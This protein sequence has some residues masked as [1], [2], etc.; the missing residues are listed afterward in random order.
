M[1]LFVTRRRALQTT[2]AALA[3]LLVAF[4]IYS[5][6]QAGK[7]NALQ[8]SISASYERAFY[9]TASLLNNI[10]V[11]LE[12]AQVTG[13]GA[14]RVSLLG[15]IGRDAASAQSNL[16]ALP[17]SMAAISESLKFV[18][19]VGDIAATLSER[20]NGDLSEE[21]IELLARLHGSCVNLNNLI[22]GIV[23]DIEGGLNPLA[24]AAA[25]APVMA[26]ENVELRETEIDYPILLYDGPFSDG[27]GDAVFRALSGDDISAD[28]ALRIARRFIGED[29]ISGAW[30]AGES[31]IPMPCYEISAYTGDGLLSLAVSK[32]G[33]HAVYMMVDG[34]A[35]ERLHSQASLIDMAASF[36]KS[37]GYPP[38]EVSY[39]MTFDGYLTVNFAAVQDG[40]LLYPDLIKVQMSMESGLPVGLEAVNFLANHA[41]RR[42]PEPKLD[43]NEARERLNSAL[44]AER[45][46][47]CVI[48]LNNG[49]A[50][51]WEFSASADGARYLVYIDAMTGEER[52]IYRVVEDENGQLVI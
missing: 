42:L 22:D 29:R 23:S 17:A 5:R 24:K 26:A 20:P 49:E 39:W 47:L 25:G 37:R 11:N 50:F 28:E 52:N 9:E 40:V 8:T 44:T 27:R 6:A 51:C 48:P 31:E 43:E 38:V 35:R 46:R 3:A 10:E 18:N 41:E 15:Q 36:L 7:I 33:G 16:T 13:S 32:Q 21:E 30:I 1:K 14:R 4:V 2:A 34:A 19:Q 12:K 45:G